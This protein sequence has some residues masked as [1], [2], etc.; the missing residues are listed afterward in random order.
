MLVA[1]D[2]MVGWQ[3]LR[4]VL[5]GLI[6]AWNALFFAAFEHRNIEVLRIKMQ[7]IYKIFPRIV[8]GLALKI[9]AKAPIAQ[10]LEHGV[11]VGIVANFFQ[12][13]MLSAYAKTLLRVGSAA[14]FGVACAQN[15][16]LPL[17]HAC[18]C[19]HQCGVVFNHHGGR[20]HYFVSFPFK[21][22]F[23]GVAYFVRCHH[24]LLS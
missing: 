15:D 13:V 22:M 20:G 14:W 23:E 10:H 12:I 24:R 19:E 1:V 18:V 16:V 17:V 2:D 3:V 9:V 4:P 6:V 21:K 8:Y 11:M 7:H 5:C